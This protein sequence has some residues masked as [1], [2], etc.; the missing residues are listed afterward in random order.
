MP[1]SLSLRLPRLVFAGLLLAVVG[2]AAGNKIHNTQVIV[3][4]ST[5]EVLHVAC[6]PTVLPDGTP[7]LAQ[8][9]ALLEEVAA[10]AGGYTLIEEVAGAW[11]PP[12][13]KRVRREVN[14]LLLVK[15]PPEIALLLQERLATEFQQES[16][17]VISLPILPAAATV[18]RAQQMGMQVSP[19]Q[20]TA[21]EALTGLPAGAKK[22]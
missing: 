18:S 6:V 3:Q 12:G 15:G 13:A 8:R 5:E 11:V 7:A 19:E 9:S 21:L 2:C 22:Q 10:G 1:R 17:F 20:A 14:D 16:P 4:F